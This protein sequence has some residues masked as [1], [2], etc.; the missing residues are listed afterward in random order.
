MRINAMLEESGGELTPEIEEALRLTADNF[1][2]KAESYAKTIASYRAII[3]NCGDEIKRIEAY[4]RTCENIIKRMAE[5]LTHAMRVFG[6]DK[7]TAGTYRLS[8]RRY[9]AL[10]INDENQIPD[11]FFDFEPKLRRKDVMAALKDGERIDGCDI[12]WKRSVT[13]R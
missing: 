12:E 3:T 5:A 10:A 7:M 8:L 13:I 9:Q 6:N 11:R 1:E 4:K 2:E